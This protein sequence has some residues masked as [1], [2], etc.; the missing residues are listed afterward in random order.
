MPRRRL[1]IDRDPEEFSVR[2]S[3]SPGRG[4][5]PD[6]NFSPTVMR[7]TALLLRGSRTVPFI[8]ESDL[9]PDCPPPPP[10]GPPPDSPPTSPPETPHTSPPETPHT[11]P[12]ET[13]QG[14]P[15]PS[16][17]NLSATT[18][19]GVKKTET[20][21]STDTRQAQK[22]ED[23]DQPPALPPKTALTSNRYEIPDTSK[24]PATSPDGGQSSKTE[25]GGDSE[26]KPGESNE[27][28]SVSDK[29]EIPEATKESVVEERYE[30]PEVVKETAIN[31]GAS[32]VPRSFLGPVVSAGRANLEAV[33]GPP[34]P[35]RRRRNHHSP[36]PPRPPKSSAL[37][38][39]WQ[40]KLPP[41]GG[42]LVVRPGSTTSSF[43]TT[44][45]TTSGS[46]APTPSSMPATPRPVKEDK[47][48]TARRSWPFLLCDCLYAN[49][50]TYDNAK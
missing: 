46:T 31:G 2:V 17:V 37:D 38:A 41:K 29:R 15:V 34:K 28:A 5:V 21:K 25:T 44:S 40:P 18:T 24:P 12:P 8:D 47:A 26:G 1:Q 3:R 45:G 16:R 19:P 23:K 43:S 35:P 4:I 6:P 10:P 39:P 13:P 22:A 48:K 36:P 27:P 50:R 42:S 30:I 20:D 49:C 32:T 33:F 14:S 7:Q 11:S 9:P